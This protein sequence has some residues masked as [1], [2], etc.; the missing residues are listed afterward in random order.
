MAKGI[1][2]SVSN[3]LNGTI[4]AYGQTSSGKTFTMQGSGSLQEGAVKMSNDPDNVAANGGIVHMAAQDIFNHI[5]KEPERDFLVRVS[6]IEIYNEEVRDLLVSGGEGADSTLTVREDPRRGVFVN[7]NETIVT[8][9]DSLLS[10]LFAG[11]KNRSVAATGMNER[12]SRSHTIFRVT[13]ESRR[14]RAQRDEDEDNDDDEEMSDDQIMDENGGNGARKSSTNDDDDAAVRVSTLNLVDLAGSES[15]RHT[16][17]TGDRQKEG[18]KINQSL[19]TLSRVIA[20]LG[21]NATYINFRDSK[22]TRILQPS[23]SGNARMAVICCATPSELYLEETRSTLQFASRAKLVKTRAQVN[24]VMDERSL[25]K[26]LQRELKE[27]RNQAGGGPGKAE[28]EKMKALEEEAARENHERRKVEQ[29]FQRLKDSILKGG[30]SIGNFSRIQNPSTKSSLYKSLFVYN[31]DDETIKTG[32]GSADF[33]LQMS[34]KKRKSKRRFSDGVIQESKCSSTVATPLR[35]MSRQI[36]NSANMNTTTDTNF[37][38]PQS[39]G[40]IKKLQAQTEIKPKKIKP[41][42]H[43]HPF[44]KTDVDIGLLRE[45]LA[46]KSAQAAGLKAKL[47]EAQ[48]QIQSAEKRLQNENGEKEMLRLAKQDLESQVSSLACDK[49]FVVT[50]QDIVVAD[51]DDI[52]AESL[53][54][55]ELMLEQHEKLQLENESLKEER[56]KE[57]SALQEEHATLKEAQDQIVAELRMVNAQSSQTIC[58]LQAE[59]AMMMDQQIEEQKKHEIALVELQASLEEQQQRVQEAS[60]DLQIENDS[61]KEQWREE[62]QKHELAEVELRA[63]LEALEEQ[64]QQAQESIANLQI[65]NA[66]LKEQSI[67]EQQKHEL[68]VVELQASLEEQQQQ[69]QETI[70]NLETE[71]ASLKEQ[72][73]QEH[74]KQEAVAVELRASLHDSDA[75]VEDLSDKLAAALEEVDQ[76]KLVISEK[77]QCISQLEASTAESGEQLAQASAETN[78]FHAQLAEFSQTISVLEDGKSAISKELEESSETN[79]LLQNDLTSKGAQISELQDS[80]EKVTTDMEAMQMELDAAKEQ[81]TNASNDIESLTQA[82]SDLTASISAK[83]S[84]LA[85]AN[86]TIDALEVELSLSSDQINTLTEEITQLRSE[87]DLAIERASELE[88]SLSESE[89]NLS[90]RLAA[91]TSS[92]QESV[93]KVAR[94]EEETEKLESSIDTEKNVSEELQQLLNETELDV[95]RLT[96]ENNTAD[97]ENLE[98]SA[99]LVEVTTARDEAAKQLEEANTVLHSRKE[100]NAMLNHQLSDLQVKETELRETISSLQSAVQGCNDEISNLNEIIKLSSIKIEELT[101][102]VSDVSAERDGLIAKVESTAAEHLEMQQEE[103]KAKS[104]IS[105]LK[106]R[107]ESLVSDRDT[108]ESRVTELLSGTENAGEIM[109][110]LHAEKEILVANAEENRKELEQEKNASDQ[111]ENNLNAT[112]TEL[113]KKNDTLSCDLEAA[114]AKIT[115]ISSQFEESITKYNAL[116][117]EYQESLNELE[118]AI[119]DKDTIVTETNDMKSSHE[120]QVAELQRSHQEQ[121]DKIELMNQDITTSRNQIA[122]LCNKLSSLSSEKEDLAAKVDLGSDLES[123]LEEANARCIIL[124]EEKNNYT[125]ELELAMSG[126]ESSH[127]KRKEVIQQQA[128]E[129]ECLKQNIAEL[130]DKLSTTSAEREELASK[131]VLAADEIS[132][133][134]DD[135]WKAKST[136]AELESTVKS[137]VLEREQV[138][139]IAAGVEETVITLQSEK[140]ALESKVEE[141]IVRLE[142]QKDGMEQR[143]DSLNAI[144]VELNEKNN[145]LDNEV[146]EFKS[147]SCNL[148]SQMEEVNAK[149]DAL[150]SENQDCMNE[151]EQVISENE[152]LSYDFSETEAKYKQTILDLEAALTTKMEEVNQLNE[153]ITALDNAS[154][155]NNESDNSASG[156]VESLNREIVELKSLLS[157]ANESVEQA[158]DAA[159]AADEELGEKELQLERALQAVDEHEEA[160]RIAEE[161]LRFAQRSPEICHGN[162]ESQEELLHDIDILMREKDE[163][164]SRLQ[165]EINRQKELEDEM[166]MA[167]EE[168]KMVLMNEAEERMV[169]LKDEIRQLKSDLSRVE[170]ECYSIKDKCRDLQDENGRVE[171]KAKHSE[172]IITSMKDELNREMKNKQEIE[173]RLERLEEESATFKAQVFAAKAALE[174]ES[175]DK[176]EVLHE[177]LSDALSNLNKTQHELKLSKQ[178]IADLTSDIDE[179]RR[180]LESV[181]NIAS[182]EK[183]MEMSKLREDV[184]KLKVQL[185]SS[186]SDYLRAKQ[187]LDKSKEKV[188]RVDKCAKEKQKKFAARAE[189]SIKHLQSEL[190]R[191]QEALKTAAGTSGSSALVNDNDQAE[192]NALQ[193]KMKEL[194]ATI[195]EK[196]NRIKYLE[197]HKVTKEMSEMVQKLKVSRIL[198]NIDEQ[199]RYFILIQFAL[200]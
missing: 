63:S 46:A 89:S 174:A 91:A 191:A 149:F 166:K 102:E 112:I 171:A 182:N 34:V 77:T 175:Q 158:R 138:E 36:K 18:G 74:Q 185:T 117:S 128:N 164:E 196:D 72:S 134:Q 38:S 184:A 64:Q 14:K 140:A 47:H 2:Q 154:T 94:L 59:N 12:S 189:A 27:A 180:Q 160:R 152:R 68:A 17:A 178:T 125:N 172:S 119:N 97:A 108:A 98:L 78:K 114:N 139:P 197:K 105:E 11:E 132:N 15:V 156:I 22:L 10:V 87:K 41:T 65:E 9:L 130:N 40:T 7:S 163:A 111:R 124:E 83:E 50:E 51:K 101:N 150:E 131:V 67:E 73:S 142:A 54:K 42:T 155:G 48:C 23:L 8:G 55:I 161:R 26:K 176:L 153:Q 3:G 141:Y 192:M 115:E 190:N 200:T 85:E 76:L 6:F 120:Q 81:F 21:Q 148:V 52:I 30:L 123:Q 186:N 133:M 92:L 135:A 69:A 109:T 183:E 110:A 169:V 24:E 145:A 82:N 113:E 96:E 25:I 129:I 13:V 20:N 118:L 104:T 19:L 4:F 136:I 35:D 195:Q 88:S 93:S 1:V 173:E 37:S 193:I 53:K 159:L 144:I 179:Y 143:A 106:S 100:E 29:D 33:S 90:E 44:E 45:A 147:K 126:I 84:E 167:A 168:E 28:I 62:Q 39:S 199:N 79:S 99:S 95:F 177:R 86:S 181:H 5:E 194:K 151:L 146:N 116:N 127:A 165:Q 56:D 32:A 31:N 157:S 66:S 61:L 107:I 57:V 70:S 187:D 121:L 103:S 198:L 170:S 58:N 75:R 60:S 49:D 122:D 188:I 137:L 43:I 80:L 16:G 162:S 71:N